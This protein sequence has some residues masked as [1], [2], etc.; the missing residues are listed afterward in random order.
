MI[1]QAGKF[2]QQGSGALVRASG[3]STLWWRSESEMVTCEGWSM[4]RGLAHWRSAHWL[5]RD[6]L[7]LCVSIELVWPP[8]T[9]TPL[10][11]S[12]PTPQHGHIEDQ[13]SRM[14]TSGVMDVSLLANRKVIYFIWQNLIFRDVLNDLTWP[15]K[16]CQREL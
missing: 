5:P 11:D 15:H 9:W 3:C 8:G 2:N 1:M 12:P 6:C 13:V 10:L 16:M 4:Q 7:H 14:W